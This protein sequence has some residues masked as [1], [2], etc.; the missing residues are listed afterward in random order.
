MA[1]PDSAQLIALEELRVFVIEVMSA[2]NEWSEE[3]L[4]RLISLDLGVLRSNATQRHGVTRWK[5]GI[6]DPS[7]PDDVDVIDIHPMLLAGEW[8]PYGA[9][10]MHHEFIHA[11]GHLPHDSE[12]RRLEHLWPSAEAGDM[13]RKFTEYL[14]HLKARYL[15]VCPSCS[16][17]HPR[18]RAGRGKYLCRECR[19]P[20]I[21]VR[22]E[23]A[24]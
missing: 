22:I 13:G 5:H 19:K 15:W 11:L 12:F 23:P 3:I 1:R 18:Q 14:R 21:D 17:E 7:G 10:V 9:W 2:M 8:K 6:T 20:L 4:T 24:K 16:K